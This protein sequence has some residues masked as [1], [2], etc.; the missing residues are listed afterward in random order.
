[1]YHYRVKPHYEGHKTTKQ[2]VP[3]KYAFD[4]PIQNR[5][6]KHVLILMAA[7]AMSALDVEAK[8][9]LLSCLCGNVKS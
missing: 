7:K 8:P 9:K 3:F 5:S 6:L 1:M 2:M 4:V